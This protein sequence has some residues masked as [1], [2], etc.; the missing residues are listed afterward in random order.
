MKY[1]YRKGILWLLLYAFLSLIPLIIARLGPQPEY[2]G[3]WME[4]G[5]A[6]GFIGLGMLAMQCLF[7]GRFA[8]I[9]PGFGMDNILQYHREVGIIAFVFVLA[10][11]VINLLADTTLLEYLD[12]GVNAPRTISLII[13]TLALILIVVSSLWRASLK[14]SYENWRL[15]HGILSFL[16]VVIGAGHAF[17]VAHYLGP[18]WKQAAILGFAGI[19]AYLVFHSRVMRPWLNRPR[20]YRISLVRDERCDC[21]TLVLE[22]L[23]GQR[24]SFLPGQ[25]VWITV[26]DSPFSLQQH[27]FSIASSAREK[28]IWLTAKNL[29]DFTASWKEIPEGSRAFLEGPYGSFTPK[30]DKNLFLVMG[31]IG[32]TPA[33]S[34]LRTMAHDRD[35]RQVILIYANKNWDDILA[36]QELEQLQAK[37]RLKLVHLL[38]EAPPDWKG[39]EGL[40]NQELIEKYLPQDPSSFAYY[41]C[42]PEPVMD[43]AEMSLRNLGIDWRLIYT[44]RFEII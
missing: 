36:R 3:F 18:V 12:P 22:P 25:F 5:V 27:P 16:V 21:Q 40:L 30:K 17:Q 29:G 1:T 26:N 13:A 39:E 2:R 38:E 11:P 33:M 31:G 41:I 42:G 19:C 9:A 44:E 23:R 28:N 6:L 35:Q 34:M 14:L 7:T 20:P 15:L 4:F 32:I 24:L 43:I 8:W 37:I 10:H